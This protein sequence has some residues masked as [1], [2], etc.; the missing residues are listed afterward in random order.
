MRLTLA[1]VC[2]FQFQI[3]GSGPVR[4]QMPNLSF[5]TAEGINCQTGPRYH[6]KD[7]IRMLQRYVRMPRVIIISVISSCTGYDGA[8]ISNSTDSAT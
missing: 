1:T 6:H 2:I 8:L 5:A 3:S 4:L 7:S